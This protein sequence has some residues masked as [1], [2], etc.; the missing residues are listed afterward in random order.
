MERWA[1]IVRQY[2]PLGRQT[3]YRL[4]GNDADAADC[5]KRYSSTPSARTGRKTFDIGSVCFN[6]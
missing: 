5:F 4:L 2:G 1:D 6:G 3:A